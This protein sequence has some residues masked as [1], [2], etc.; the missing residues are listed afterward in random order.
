MIK[1]DRKREKIM[2]KNEMMKI[3]KMM[4]EFGFEY[5]F[6]EEN[7]K[8]SLSKKNYNEL[9]EFL[10]DNE[11]ER[12]NINIDNFE[13]KNQIHIKRDRDIK[14]DMKK[15][16]N[17]NI[18]LIYHRK[19][20]NEKEFRLFISYK[21]EENNL[22]RIRMINDEIK[23]IHSDEKKMIDYFKKLE[24]KNQIEKYLKEKIS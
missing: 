15:I 12:K 13:V 23:S 5:D 18:K 24:K 2:K 10:N 11:E 1:S 7:Q 14:I 4:N 6:N 20:D 16:E 21:D 3:E 8:Y 17:Y 9:I 22:K 19:K